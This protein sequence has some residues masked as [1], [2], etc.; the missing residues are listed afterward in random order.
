MD[1]NIKKIIILG[2]LIACQI[3]IGRFL[4]ISTLFVKIGFVFLP[5]VIAAILYGPFWAGLSAA[6]GDIVVAMLLPYGYFPGFTLSAFLTGIIYGLFLYGKPLN[7][8]RIACCVLVIHITI[9]IFLQTYWLFLFTGQGYLIVLPARVMQALIMMPIQVLC[10][11]M[12]AYRVAQ[13]AL[14]AA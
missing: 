6:I 8:W 1:P 4:T 3:V 12:I 13:I 2:M 11:R 9:G 10:I 7:I 5:I 14:K